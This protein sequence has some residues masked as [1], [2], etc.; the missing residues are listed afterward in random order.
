MEINDATAIQLFLFHTFILGQ[1]ISTDKISNE[2]NDVLSS[3]D[4][5]G[6]VFFVIWE[7]S[8]VLCLLQN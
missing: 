1:D 5:E 7:R 3:F 4:K 2:I 8:Q 6:T